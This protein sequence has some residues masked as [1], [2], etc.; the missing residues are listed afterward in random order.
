M[1]AD[2]AALVGLAGGL[3][4][5]HKKDGTICWQILGMDS[6]DQLDSDQNRNFQIESKRFARN[7]RTKKNQQRKK[8]KTNLV[9]LAA[10]LSPANPERPEFRLEC[11][12]FSLEQGKV[13]MFQCDLKIFPTFFRWIA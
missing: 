11:F 6:S 9:R 7:F 3:V 8:V 10:P 4:I 2:S 1:V 5:L 13:K 12:E